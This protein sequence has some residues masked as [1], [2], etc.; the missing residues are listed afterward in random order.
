MAACRL[1]RKDCPMR[2]RPNVLVPAAALA[3]L[4]SPIAAQQVNTLPADLSAKVDAA[5][6]EVMNRTQVPSASVGVVVSDSSSR[7]P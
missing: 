5:I 4:V 1:P 6:S 2:S 7:G 3:L